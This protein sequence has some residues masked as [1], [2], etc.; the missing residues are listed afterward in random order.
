MKCAYPHFKAYRH[1]YGYVFRGKLQPTEESP[2]YTIVIKYRYGAA[3]KVFVTNPKLEESAPHT[4][5]DGSLCLF[6]PRV[7]RWH[8]GLRISKYIVPWTAFWL[9]FYEEWLELGVWHGPEAPHFGDSDWK[10]A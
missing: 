5:K 4:Y 2:S 9:Y 1:Q 10:E 3:P 8:D 6:N 7:F